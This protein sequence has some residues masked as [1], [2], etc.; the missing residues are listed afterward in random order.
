[1]TPEAWGFFS[2]NSVALIALL[3][4]QASL[5]KKVNQSPISNGVPQKTLDAVTR[6]EVTMT[7]HLEDHSDLRPRKRKS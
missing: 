3:G 2:A 7:K 6:L 4:Q 5:R 1:M